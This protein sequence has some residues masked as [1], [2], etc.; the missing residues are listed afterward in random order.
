MLQ[1]IYNNIVMTYNLCSGG[2]PLSFATPAQQLELGPKVAK[3]LGM[4]NLFDEPSVEF[5]D[6]SLD[7]LPRD[8]GRF[9]QILPFSLLILTTFEFLP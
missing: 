3:R 1:F 6:V 2:F 5:I 8:R 9:L 4:V 7:A